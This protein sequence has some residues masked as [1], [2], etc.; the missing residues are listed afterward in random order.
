MPTTISKLA[1]FHAL[2]HQH[3]ALDVLMAELIAN[4]EELRP[5]HDRV[6]PT[7]VEARN[8]ID[9]LE[10]ELAIANGGSK[11]PTWSEFSLWLAADES[12]EGEGKTGKVTSDAIEKEGGKT[13]ERNGGHGEHTDPRLSE[14]TQDWLG[15]QARANGRS[16]NAEIV[17]RLE[18]SRHDQEK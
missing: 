11:R 5:L 9:A 14:E 16:L 8:L 6:W 12:L 2:K 1:L 4:A 7:I 17:A 3:A 15:A 13:E 18:A 10:A